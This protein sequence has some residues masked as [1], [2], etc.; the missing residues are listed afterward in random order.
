MR[1]WSFRCRLREDM[2]GSKKWDS[3]GYHV[4]CSGHTY[5]YY[6]PLTLQVQGGDGPHRVQEG[7]GPEISLWCLICRTMWQKPSTVMISTTSS[8]WNTRSPK[9]L[10]S[11]GS[12]FAGKFTA[13]GWLHIIHRLEGGQARHAVQYVS[14]APRNFRRGIEF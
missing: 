4:A 13:W 6:V 12:K 2:V 14:K 8:R 9:P 3:W 7:S 10:T 11:A 1:F 5:S